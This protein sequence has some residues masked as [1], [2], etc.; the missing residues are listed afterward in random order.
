MD[1]GLSSSSS[2]DE[3]PL[4]DL[5][6]AVA[7]KIPESPTTEQRRKTI[8]ITAPHYRIYDSDSTS[9]AWT[10]DEVFLRAREGP[11]PVKQPPPPPPGGS[12]L[13]IQTNVEPESSPDGSPA[14]HICGARK[15][16]QMPRA[17]RFV[18]P[19]ATGITRRK[20]SA[21]AH[22]AEREC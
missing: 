21:C 15:D 18:V 1:S 5:E 8:Y 14:Q 19:A 9:E 2:E 16:S 17:S 20:C 4:G 22:A 3:D 7:M 10:G 12:K 11:R 13:S 6:R